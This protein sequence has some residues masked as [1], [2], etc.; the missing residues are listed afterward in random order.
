[1]HKDHL[2]L[3]I[4]VIYDDTCSLKSLMMVITDDWSLQLVLNR[5]PVDFKMGCKDMTTYIYALTWL[6]P[7]I[8]NHVFNPM[9]N[10][11]TFQSLN[12]ANVEVWD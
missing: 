9:R 12:S 5:P 1:M 4:I 3:E 2:S 7:W 11:I 10:K 6:Q 8:S